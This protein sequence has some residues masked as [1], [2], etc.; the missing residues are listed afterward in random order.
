MLWSLT[1]LLVVVTPS[2]LGLIFALSISPASAANNDDVPPSSSTSC[3]GSNSNT[4]SPSATPSK[5]KMMNDAKNN[6][7]EGRRN[8]HPFQLC[9]NILSI[10]LRFLLVAICYLLRKLIRMIIPSTLYAS[11]FTNGSRESLSSGNSSSSGEGR[12]SYRCVKLFCITMC[13][14]INGGRHRWKRYCSF[15]VI[16]AAFVGISLSLTLLGTIVAVV[17]RSN[18]SGSV[19]GF[20]TPDQ[21]VAEKGLDEEDEHNKYDHYITWFLHNNKASYSPLKWMVTMVCAIGMIIASILNGFGCASLPYGNLVGMYLKPTSP[22]ILAKVEEDYYYTLKSLEDKR[23]T[24]LDI[25]QSS[26]PSGS[27]GTMSAFRD[28][29]QSSSS[30]LY[31]HHGAPSPTNGIPTDKQKLKQLRDE[32]SFLE[33]LVGDMG[34]DIEEMKHSQQLALAA[35]TPFGRIRGVLGVIFSVVLVVRVVLAAYSF[36][37]IFRPRSS[38]SGSNSFLSSTLQSS[39]L[40][41][42]SAKDPITNLILWLIGHD[43]VSQE[44]YNLFLQGTSLLLA[45]I[46][47]MSQIRNFLRVVSALWRKL[48]RLFGISFGT[49]TT[50]GSNPIRNSVMHSA[51]LL[52]SSFA[53]GSYFLSCVVMMKMLLPIEYRSSFSAAVGSLDFEFNT[54]LLNMLFTASACTSAVVLGLLFG[55]QRNNVKRYH[56]EFQL[57]SFGATAANALSA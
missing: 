30:N 4:R 23:W 57:S 54:I 25:T 49:M 56:M 18:S 40:Q 14:F 20:V 19:D 12:G 22:I 1:G 55:I 38:E 53:M 15:P 52:L 42:N 48:S 7:E 26:E 31:Y 32:I 44:Q 2:F 9:L 3:V 35:R 43:F 24:L 34:D 21:L 47:S 33:N 51:P 6:S 50:P 29:C 45:G 13:S 8:K 41:S 5:R 36:A 46:L 28:C 10:S 27:R 39:S 11:F 37:F 17:I 16:F